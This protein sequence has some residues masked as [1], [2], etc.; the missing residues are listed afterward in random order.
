MPDQCGLRQELVQQTVEWKIKRVQVKKTRRFKLE[1]VLFVGVSSGTR[2]RQL[3]FLH[4][5]PKEKPTSK[6]T[7]TKDLILVKGE[8]V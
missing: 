7:P 6:I 4:L 5:L 1:K 3:Y 2:N 8:N